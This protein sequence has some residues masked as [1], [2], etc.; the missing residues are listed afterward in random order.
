MKDQPSYSDH[1]ATIVA[2]VTHL[3][4]TKWKSRTPPAMAK[5]LGL[6]YQE[7]NL[8]LESFKDLFR[9]SMRRDPDS[10][11]YYYT[12]QQRYARRSFDDPGLQELQAQP[13]K[14]LEPEDLDKLIQYITNAVKNEQK[15]MHQDSAN[16]T[17]LNT[18]LI[19]AAVAILAT[20]I[21]AVVTK[22]L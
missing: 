13:E 3:A 1:Q 4:L 14:P 12:L 10:N 19:L 15:G 8:V 21:T 20:V 11:E 17:V 2:L 6:D 22:Y 7:V 5:A 16:R 18:T 9:K